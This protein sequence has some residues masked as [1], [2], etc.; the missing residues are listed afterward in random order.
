MAKN[1]FGRR[2]QGRTCCLDLC[3]TI[4]SMLFKQDGAVCRKGITCVSIFN[5]ERVLLVLR[6]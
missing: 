1:T 6:R 3:T 5:F 2:L 4:F